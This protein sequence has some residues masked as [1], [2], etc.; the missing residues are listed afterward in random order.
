MI[1]RVEVDGFK[2]LRAFALDLER[3]T[4]LIGPNGAGK[5]NIVDA[6]ALLSRLASDDLATALQGGR[7]RIREQ[8]SSLNE[9]TQ[10]RGYGPL[11]VIHLAVEMLLLD[12][13]TDELRSA[14]DLL[15]RRVRYEVDIELGLLSQGLVDRCMLL[16]EK[17]I[18]MPAADPWLDQH[19]DFDRGIQRGDA[20]VLLSFERS[21]LH[22]TDPLTAAPEGPVFLQHARQRAF[23]SDPSAWA[24][25]PH[26][27][28]V[29]VELGRLRSA[30]LEPRVLREPSD[31]G[32][33]TMTAEGAHLAQ[34]LAV[35][36][37]PSP[38]EKTTAD[39][40][41]R[42]GAFARIQAR[43]VALIPGVRMLTVVP[44]AH[45]VEVEVELT[46]GQRFSSRVLSDGTL[47]VLG[48]L[49]LLETTPPGAVLA[50]EEPE[51]GVHPSRARALLDI[52]REAASDEPDAEEALPAQVV[53]T[54]HSPAVLAALLDRPRDI[55]V[56]DMVRDGAGPR[57]SRARRLAAAGASDRGE[58]S[59]SRGEIERLLA[60]ATA[61][62]VDGGGP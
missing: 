39:L 54:S 26:L 30:H 3:F 27:R 61:P 56:I 40:A 60:T 12:K 11:G 55:A 10:Q 38:P 41:R 15:F 21:K 44:T 50:I 47:R 53:I 43:L 29:A 16:T 18:A 33:P 13:K 51:N 28:A 4:A 22:I 37:A 52:L 59:V 1:T 6:L 62:P 42:G 17:L 23:L 14:P 35:L 58:R 20:Q 31:R 46:D 32:A 2:S 45:T 24:Q 57:R 36:A 7:G 5:S 8:F 48:L 25:S 9:E 49:T 19:P 34:E